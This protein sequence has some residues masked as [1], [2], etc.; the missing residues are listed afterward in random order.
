MVGQFKLGR[1]QQ[2][3]ERFSLIGSPDMLIKVDF[4]KKNRTAK[5]DGK[6]HLHK[7]ISSSLGR[8]VLMPDS[9]LAVWYFVVF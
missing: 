5:H 9:A 4:V 8:G 6:L 2:A 3:E 7:A 1:L